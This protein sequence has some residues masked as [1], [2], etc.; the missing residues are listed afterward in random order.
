MLILSRR[1]NEG[2]VVTGP[3][4][5]VVVELRRGAVRLG[6]E[7]DPAVAIHRDEVAAAIVSREKDEEPQ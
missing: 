6:I 2:I 5:I 1:A 4:H 3:C 7:A